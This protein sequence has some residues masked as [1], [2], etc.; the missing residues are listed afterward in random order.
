M[1]DDHDRS[2]PDREGEIV[3][4]PVWP[5]RKEKW[6]AGPGMAAVGTSVGPLASSSS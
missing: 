3:K 1:W 5:G 6:E 2:G 4:D